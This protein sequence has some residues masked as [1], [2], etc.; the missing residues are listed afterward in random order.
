MKTGFS[1]WELIHREFP[2]SY[3][4]FGFT[5]ETVKKLVWHLKVLNKIGQH[6]QHLGSI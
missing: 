1:L 2:V 6:D 3:T 4:G 5:K